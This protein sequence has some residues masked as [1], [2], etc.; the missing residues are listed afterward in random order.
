LAELDE[1]LDS[2]HAVALRTKPA[3][4]LVEYQRY[5]ICIGLGLDPTVIEIHYPP[6]DGEF[7]TS[8]GDSEPAEELVDFYGKGGHFQYRRETFVPMAEAREAVRAFIL[9]GRRS[10]RIQWR[11]WSGEPADGIIDYRA[12]FHTILADPRYQRNLDWGEP[13]RGHP[14]GTVRAHIAELERNLQ[15]LKQRVSETDFWKLKVLIHTHNS[16]KRDARPGAPIAS[17]KSHASLARA[18]LAEFCDDPDLL[19]IVQY[20]DEPYALYRQWKSKGAFEPARLEELINA[21]EDWNLFLV[22]SIIDGCTEGKSREP[23]RWFFVQVG[24]RVQCSFTAAD[25]LEAL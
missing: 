17:P 14:E 12:I 21:I 2:I 16:F 19:A 18:F 3:L 6:C 5:G 23:V 25:I 20:H 1:R 9:T 7:Y 10:D 11:D 24:G 13:R 22:F 15:A 8:A 4:G